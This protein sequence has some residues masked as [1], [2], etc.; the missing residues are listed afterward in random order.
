VRQSGRSAVLRLRGELDLASANQLEAAI[1][2]LQDPVEVV[3]DLGGLTFLDMAGLR[4]LIT[5]HDDAARAGQRFVLANVS[6]PIRRVLSLAAAD[7]VLP[8]S[9][10]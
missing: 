3:I 4:V 6:K 2:H 8:V 9:G 10:R 1:R 7:T 5:A